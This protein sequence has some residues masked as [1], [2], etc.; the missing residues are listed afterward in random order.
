MLIDFI[1]CD[2]VPDFNFSKLNDQ[3]QF[4]NL[5]T[6]VGGPITW[7][8]TADGTG[9]STMEEPV[10]TATPPGPV[11]ICLEA[12]LTLPNGQVCVEEVCKIIQLSEI[13]G[14][15]TNCGSEEATF[16][17]TSMTDTTS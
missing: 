12:T 11:T 9:F 10:Y 16:I 2:L 17:I 8:W 1:P 13:M 15:T 3:L 14:D 4:T 5:T 6:P 7:N